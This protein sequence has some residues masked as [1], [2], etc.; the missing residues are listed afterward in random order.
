MNKITELLNDADPLQYE[1]HSPDESV[2]QAARHV[3]LSAASDGPLPTLQERKSVRFI[4][5]VLIAAGL[6]LLATRFWPSM[7]LPSHAAVPFEVR[8]AEAEPGPG[9]REARVKGG[10]KAIYLHGEVIVSNAD[11][12]RAYLI[13]EDTPPRF[14]VGIDFTSAG[15]EKMRVAT[16]QHLGHPVAIILD[17][18]VVM[19][20]VLKSAIDSSA[21]ITGQFT[22]AEAERIVEGLR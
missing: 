19:A 8:L 17:N 2:K 18:E 13:E 22:K 21:V 10:S 3:I 7:V 16:G 20:P 6:L 5:A 15:A 1:P 11:I 12:A 9:L 14:A 4:T